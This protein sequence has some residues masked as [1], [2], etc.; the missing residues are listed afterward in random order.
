MCGCACFGVCAGFASPYDMT[1]QS[2]AAPVC[3]VFCSAEEEEA[4]SSERCVW[5]RLRVLVCLLL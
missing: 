3:D 2:Y 4:A 1:V 5:V